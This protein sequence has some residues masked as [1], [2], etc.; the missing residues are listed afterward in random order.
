MIEKIQELELKN[1][2]LITKCKNIEKDNLDKIKIYENKIGEI[3]NSNENQFHEIISLQNKLNESDNNSLLTAKSKII[4]ELINK[5]S[6]LND[7]VLTLNC[8]VEDLNRR[9]IVNQETSRNNT[10]DSKDYKLE[11]EKKE[12]VINSLEKKL[13]EFNNKNTSYNLI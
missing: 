1:T 5:N 11:L 9:L 12:S 3:K 8:I 13:R 4:E 10:N 7:K 6:C 2:D